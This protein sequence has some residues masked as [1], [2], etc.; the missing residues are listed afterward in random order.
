M[1][2]GPAPLRVV[3]LVATVVL[4]ACIRHSTAPPAATPAPANAGVDETAPATPAVV[5]LAPAERHQTLEGFG[6][7]VAW[8]QDKLVPNPP[9]GIYETIFPDLGLDILRLRNRFHRMVKQEDNNIAQDVEIVRRATAALGHPPKILMSSWSPPAGLKANHSEDCHDDKN[10]TLVRENGQFVYDKFGAYWH[11]ALVYYASQGIVPDWIS[12]ENEPSFIPPSW[13]G[14]KFDPSETE[15]FPGYDKALTAVH[16]A[17]ATLP[18]RPKI[19]GLAHVA[20]YVRDLAKAR[21]FYK[22][23]LGF[24]EEPFTLKKNDGAERI[25]FIKINDRQYL[26]LFAEDP[27]NDGRLN[28]IWSIPTTAR[29]CVRISPRRE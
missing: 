25:V 13:E 16:A 18:K 14:C 29:G 23:F 7:A 20:F 28:H 27:K 2:R 6:A 17:V 11:D 15:H 9:A 21:T 12:I 8:Y 19:L 10:C 22:D 1:S 5:T 4:A 3:V 24:D 26:E